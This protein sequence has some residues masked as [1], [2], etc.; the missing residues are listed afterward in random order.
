M[1]ERVGDVTVHRDD[2]LRPVQLAI[3]LP[4][5]V[6]ASLYS[7]D[8]PSSPTGQSGLVWL[9]IRSPEKTRVSPMLT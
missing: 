6:M 2:H 9:G 5:Q 4:L 8:L 3:P 7:Q 1:G